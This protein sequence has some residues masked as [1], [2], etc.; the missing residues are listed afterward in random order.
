M[1]IVLALFLISL[2]IM[3]HEGG[4]YLAAKMSGVQIYEFS[5][6]F[7]PKVFQIKTKRSMLVSLRAIPLGGYVRLAG[8]DAAD[9]GSMVIDGLARFQ[10]RPLLSRLFI[11]SAGSLANL[12][13]SFVILWFIYGA[14]GLRSSVTTVIQSVG[15]GSPAAQVQILPGD[16]IVEVD[17]VIVPDGQHLVDVIR[18]SNGKALNLKILRKD[19]VVKITVN[20]ERK[21][22]ESTWQIGI[23]LGAQQYDRYEWGAALFRAIHDTVQGVVLTLVGLWQLFTGKMGLSALSGPIGIVSVTGEMVNYGVLHL[24]RFVAF[25]GINLAVLNWLPLPA[26]DGGR[27]LIEGLQVV[28]PFRLKESVV[29]RIHLVGAL[30]LVMLMF[31]ITWMDITKLGAR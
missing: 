24:G 16:R 14:G 26:L 30:M 29:A 28:L 4:H 12:I 8:L 18:A 21:S 22:P 27:F 15:K 31:L 17:R 20:P 13:L 19:V 25:L 7:G 3:V 5:V 9:E 11:L 6:G 1:T 2:L 10:D 23:K